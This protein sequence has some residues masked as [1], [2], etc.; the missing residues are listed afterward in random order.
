MEIYSILS[1]CAVIM[2]AVLFDAEHLKCIEDFENHYTQKKHIVHLQNP[3]ARVRWIIMHQLHRIS[4]GPNYFYLMIWTDEWIRFIVHYRV[5][6]NILLYQNQQLLLTVDF[7]S[8]A[9]LFSPKCISFTVPMLTWTNIMW[10]TKLKLG[11]KLAHLYC[12][13]FGNKFFQSM[14]PLR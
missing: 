6:T 10:F 12:R 11:Y 14:K 13:L 3:D 1:V 4:R 5:C 9:V 2:P 8:L 7:V